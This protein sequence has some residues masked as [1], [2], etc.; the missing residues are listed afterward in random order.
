MPGGK[1]LVV[2]KTAASAAALAAVLLLGAAC[3]ND[4]AS[5]DPSPDPTTSSA[6]SSPSPTDEATGEPTGEPSSTVAPATGPVLDL[7]LASVR[8]PK[9]WFLTPRIVP[10]QVDAGTREYTFS[11]ITLAQIKSY[12][13]SM[14]ADGLADNWLE[15]SFYPRQ[16]K[17]LPL[18]ELDGTEAYHLAGQ[19]QKNLYLEEFGAQTDGKV[20][21]LTFLFSPAASPEERQDVIDATLAT[22]TWK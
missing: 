8:A 11:S 19:V 21:A 15:S 2:P 18:T 9:G 14:S 6:T 10:Q 3:G 4:D 12:D 5:A 7:P 17:K 16:P 20:V 22:F 1:V 13:L